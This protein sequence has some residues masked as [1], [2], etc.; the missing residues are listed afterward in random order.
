MIGQM[1]NAT[2]M[3]VQAMRESVAKAAEGAA[4]AADARQAIDSIVEDSRQALEVVE[5]INRQ[6]ELQRRIVEGMA[7]EVE[8]VARL[9]ETSNN[10]AQTSAETAQHM[11]GLA[12]ALR[13]EVGVFRT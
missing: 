2:Q 4:I 1:Q 11:A 7:G 8:N 9:A 12:D 13:D 3:A 10:A 5:A 6:M